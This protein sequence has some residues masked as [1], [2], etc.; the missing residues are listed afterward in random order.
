MNDVPICAIV[1]PSGTEGVNPWG[2]ILSLQARRTS[3]IDEDGVDGS[4]SVGTVGGK[5]EGR[6]GKREG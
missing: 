1:V 4:I 2:W 6:K 5:M 3:T